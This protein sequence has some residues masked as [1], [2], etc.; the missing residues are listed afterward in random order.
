MSYHIN[1]D[2]KDLIMVNRHPSV[3]PK[4]AAVAN[5]VASQKEDEPASPP[6]GAEHQELT[7]KAGDSQELECFNIVAISNQRAHS[8]LRSPSSAEMHVSTRR[9]GSVVITGRVPPTT[10]PT[11]TE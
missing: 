9:R 5:A 6:R 4:E 8:S 2:L 1:E 11:I 10:E 7:S 3:G